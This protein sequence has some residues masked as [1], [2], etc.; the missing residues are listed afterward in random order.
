MYRF[1]ILQ[2]PCADDPT[3]VRTVNF[4]AY[5]GQALRK[6]KIYGWLCWCLFLWFVSFGQA[7]E[8]NK[9]N[10]MNNISFT[11]SFFNPPVADCGN[12][13][14]FSC[15]AGFCSVFSDSLDFLVLLYQDKRTMKVKQASPQVIPVKKLISY[16][17]Y[18]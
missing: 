11:S 17:H 15:V 2:S 8:M 14:L 4:P 9:S 18:F 3:K 1:I 12:K 16:C 10:I 13:F 7:K 6:K 5:A